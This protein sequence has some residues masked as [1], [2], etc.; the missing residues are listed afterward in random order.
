MKVDR[1]SR[2]RSAQLPTFPFHVWQWLDYGQTWASSHAFRTAIEWVS[3]WWRAVWQVL[4]AETPQAC[5]TP[6][7]ME[8]AT[9]TVMQAPS[10]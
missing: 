10:D 6:P 7:P 8:L 1:G 5:S 4:R 3:C 9:L 2:R